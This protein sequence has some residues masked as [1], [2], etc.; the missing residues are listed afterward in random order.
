MEHYL[1]QAVKF[2]IYSGVFDE[3]H[4]YELNKSLKNI[5]VPMVFDD[6]ADVDLKASVVLKS[7]VVWLIS[8]W[9]MIYK[10]KKKRKKKSKKKKKKKIKQLK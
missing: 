8:M 7:T 2:G 3:V 6:L 9:L 4:E 1:R 10:L 5:D